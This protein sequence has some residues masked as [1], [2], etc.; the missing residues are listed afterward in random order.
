MLQSANKANYFMFSIKYIY[1][2]CQIDSSHNNRNSRQNANRNTRTL[3]M[4]FHL[5]EFLLLSSCLSV[6]FLSPLLFSLYFPPPPPPYIWTCQLIYLYM[7]ALLHKT[8]FT[9]GLVENADDVRWLQCFMRCLYRLYIIY[10]NNFIPRSID[11]CLF[12]S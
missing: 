1:Y 2:V 11:V 9:G 10:V 5:N 6:S 4:L 8:R 3:L 12:C 7:P